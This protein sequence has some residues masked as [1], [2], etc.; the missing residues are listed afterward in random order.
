MLT[1]N[2][3]AEANSMTPLD[4]KLWRVRRGLSQKRLA[5]LLGVTQQTLSAW[6]GRRANQLG[7]IPPGWR[8]EVILDEVDKSL[9]TATGSP[10]KTDKAQIS[11]IV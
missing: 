7:R 6:E 3:S 9:E 5:E 1:V 2:K 8:I 10:A 11:K 4:L